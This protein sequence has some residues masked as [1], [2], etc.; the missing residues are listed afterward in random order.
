MTDGTLIEP[1][2]KA[3]EEEVSLWGAE[4]VFVSGNTRIVVYEDDVLYITNSE[5][6]YTQKVI[7]TIISELEI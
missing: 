3:T 7:K 1:L 4:E 5:V 6:D 2:V